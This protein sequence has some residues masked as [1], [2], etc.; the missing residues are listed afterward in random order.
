[1]EQPRVGLGV[2]VFNFGL[3]RACVPWFGCE[4]RSIGSSLASTWWRHF[5][6]AVW[7]FDGASLDHRVQ[8]AHDGAECRSLRRMV[9]RMGCCSRRAHGGVRDVLTRVC[10]VGGG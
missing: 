4:A 7:C 9:V 3:A 8:V 6:V 10:V 1:M 5:R 2:D